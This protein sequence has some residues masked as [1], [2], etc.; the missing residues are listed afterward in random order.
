MRTLKFSQTLQVPMAHQ[1]QRIRFERAEAHELKPQSVLDCPEPPSLW[2]E[3]LSSSKRSVFP[4]SGNHELSSKSSKKLLLSNC[5]LPFLHSF[6]PFLSWGRTYDAKKLRH[7][8][9]AGL[10]LASLS[11]PQ[12]SFLIISESR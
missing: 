2:K 8:F 1:E 11:I 10:T 5:F 4:F 9:F 6:F 12:V 3:V 7:D